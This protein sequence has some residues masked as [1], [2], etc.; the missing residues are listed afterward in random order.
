MAARIFAS[1][2]VRVR[3][4]RSG[5]A[6]REL[7]CEGVVPIIGLAPNGD[8][9]PKEV[10]RDA[11]GALQ[12]DERLQTALPGLFAIGVVRSGFGRWLVEAVLDARQAARNAR[13]GLA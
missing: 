2:T 8:T 1:E 7:E 10:L 5:T 3:L 6:Q 11:A 4:R 9:A 12:V 13:A